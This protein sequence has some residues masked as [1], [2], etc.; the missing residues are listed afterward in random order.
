LDYRGLVFDLFHRIVDPEDFRPKDFRRTERA[1]EV[2]GVDAEAFSTYWSETSLIRNTKRSMT[3]ISLIERFLARKGV[4]CDRDLLAK[5]D[6]ELGRFQDMALVNPH[7]EVV[8]ALRIM[9]HHGLKLGLLT[10]CDERDVR[11]W[12]NSPIA[13]FFHSVCFSFDIGVMKPALRAYQTVLERL[14]E[15]SKESV[16]VGDGGSDEL[17]GAKAAGFALVVF[18]EGFVAL[19]GL[20]KP[21]EIQGFRSMADTS[22]QRLDALVPLLGVAK[23]D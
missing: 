22:I 5:A 8:S 20:R 19:N 18:M 1:A 16:Y 17:S 11:Q 15:T 6:H 2:L 12:P 9:R 10:N 14:G 13:P 3:A 23:N 21:S 4:I 7:E